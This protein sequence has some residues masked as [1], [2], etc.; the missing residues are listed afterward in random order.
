MESCYFFIVDIEIYRG[1]LEY[2][3]N[4]ISFFRE[5]LKKVLVDYRIY[6]V[7]YID[8]KKIRRQGRVSKKAK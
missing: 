2:I 1:F 6:M 5:Y 3:F 7:K 8:D 4:L